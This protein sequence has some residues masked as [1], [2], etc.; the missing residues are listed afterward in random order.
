MYVHPSKH[1]TGGFVHWNIWNSLW[2]SMELPLSAKEIIVLLPRIR[3]LRRPSARRSAPSVEPSPLAP[4]PPHCLRVRVL[5][6]V[7]SRG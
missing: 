1:P 6:H 5:F 3:L 7:Y 4:V 2:V